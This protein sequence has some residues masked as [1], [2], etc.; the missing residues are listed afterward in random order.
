MSINKAFREDQV[1]KMAKVIRENSKPEDQDL[2]KAMAYR[3]YN[4]G[5]RMVPLWVMVIWATLYDWIWWQAACVAGL[6]YFT[7]FAREEFANTLAVIVIPAIV[8]AAL[9]LPYYATYKELKQQGW[10]K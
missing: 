3:I 7:L 6:I 8:V 9:I 5:G 4:E 1:N 2:S 10:Y